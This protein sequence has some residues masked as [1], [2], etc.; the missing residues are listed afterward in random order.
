M[1]TYI[2]TPISI[3]FETYLITPL[4]IALYFEI[5][6]MQLYLFTPVLNVVQFEITYI[7]F[8]SVL[9]KYILYDILYVYTYIII[10]DLYSGLLI[11]ENEFYIINGLS[12]FIYW[13][14]FFY[15]HINIFVKHNL[16]FF[17]MV[18]MDIETNILSLMVGVYEYI[19]INI[20][21]LY[22]SFLVKL[23]N[24]KKWLVPAK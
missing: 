24:N 10:N 22:D 9:Y 20:L 5:H 19:F 16:N 3:I 21:S 12:L 7:Y 8:Y 14:T 11:L 23:Y 17:L 4:Y 1:E 13:S 6:L 15:N 2:K 18:Y